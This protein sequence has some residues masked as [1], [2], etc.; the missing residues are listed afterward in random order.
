MDILYM[1]KKRASIGFGSIKDLWLE[2]EVL[3]GKSKFAIILPESTFRAIRR[4]PCLITLFEIYKIT[5]VFDLKNPYNNTNAIMFLYVF[6]KTFKGSTKYGIYRNVLR[7]RIGRKR[8]PGLC[9]EYPESYFDYLDYVEKVVDSNINPE[10][11]SDY[12]FGVFNEDLVAKRVW[13]PNRYCK[14]AIK[15]RA[16]LEKEKTVALGDVADIIIPNP[17]HERRHTK[18]VA[19]PKLWDYPVN[20]S[21]LR[22][23]VITDS[24]LKKGDIVSYNGQY[25]FVYEEPPCE[26]HTSPN[27]RIIRPV[28]ICPEYLYLYLSSETSM[29]IMES[30]AMGSVLRR[31]R[32]NDMADFPVVFPTLQVQHYRHTFRIEKFNLDDISKYNDVL[33]EF[34]NNNETVEDILNVELAHNIK[35]CKAEVMEQFLDSD[36]HELNTCFRHEAYKATLILAGSILEAVLIDWLSEIK[37]KNFFEEDYIVIDRNGH[38]KRADLIDYINEIKMIKRPNW[39][40]EADKAHVIRKKRNLVHAKLCMNTD[41]ISKEVCE[42][43][44]SYL[45]DVLVTRSGKTKIMC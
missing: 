36:L 39:M 3:A 43:V 32:T 7:N 44:I 34:S 6:D 4:N 18:F 22:E 5:H 9:S 31:V 19:M 35:L 41:E 45:K 16:A 1:L 42:E 17:D 13:N 11:G 25:F 24:P 40:E 27:A 23:G 14:Q 15:L 26:I 28:N 30:L 38:P 33:N 12:E 37:N 8:E 20:Y 10:D 21:K 29:I 2:E